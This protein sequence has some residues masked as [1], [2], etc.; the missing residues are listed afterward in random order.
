MKLGYIGMGTMGLPMA[1]NLLAAG[2]ELAV[3]NRTSARAD[4]LVAKGAT[5]AESAT[6]LAASVEVTMLCLATPPVCEEVLL[7]PDG[8]IA[9][10]PAGTLLIDF[11][12]N[13]PDTAGR[14]DEA[15]AAGGVGFLDAPVSGGPGG[16]EAGTLAIMVG[17]RDDDF[18]RAAPLLDIMGGA[19]HHMGGVGAG[20]VA[21]IANQLI[22]G[23]S[24]AVLAEAFVM[25]AKY[26]LDVRQ[27]YEVLMASSS[28][29]K[30]MERNV[31]GK[32]LNRD[33]SPDFSVDLL[34]KDLGLAMDLARQTG[35]RSATGAMADMLLREAR[36]LGYGGE[37]IAAAAR[38]LEDLAGT[39]VESREKAG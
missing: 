30:A 3:Y 6:A 21:K 8:V 39:R 18:A 25:A 16:A 31:G 7:G 19:V 4:A 14:C 10:M 32:I 24:L 29:S 15:A 34:S 5:R 13:G 23:T 22:V 33:F 9:A 36:A 12:S 37:D 27:L 26:G 1:A 17:G 2:H 38:V 11:S 35:T 28:G 20:S